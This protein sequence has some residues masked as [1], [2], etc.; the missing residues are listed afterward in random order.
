MASHFD[1]YIPLDRTFHELAI[2]PSEGDDVDLPLQF[3]KRETL[4]WPSLLDEYR[5]ILLSE[6][7]SGKTEEIRNTARALRKDGEH[8]F[9]VR[10]EHVSQDFEDAFEEG[11]LE[12]FNAWAA[13]G[14]EGWLL[15]DSVDE[16]RL[17]DPKDFERAIR[18]L[19]R[20]LSPVLQHAHIVIT[21]R[22]TAWRARTD[23][24][25]CRA[26]FPYYQVKNA[27]DEDALGEDATGF[28]TQQ[29][30]ARTTPTTP[31]KI[32]A[33]DDLH[34]DQIDT[35]LRGRQVKDPKAFRAAVE[36]KDAWSLT[37]RPQ[38]LAE[39][40]EFWNDHQ[41]IGSRF[42]L[43]QS[44]ISRRLEERDQ[45]RSESRPIASKRLRAGAQLVAAASTLA[46]E[47][48][49]RVP[50]GTENSKG[51]AIR[52]VLTDW[53]DVDCATLL[54]RPIFDEGIYG[55]VRFH[56]RSVREYLTAEWLHSLIVDESSRA[57]IEGLFFQSQYGIE[58]VVP[59]MRPVLPWLAILD[60]RILA[61]VCRLA[62][63]ILFEGGDPS[64]LPHETR[65]NILRQAC[66][67]LAQPAHG[68]SLTDYSAVQ[69]F[70]NADLSDDI[71]AL[72]AQYGED[73]D[74]A[75]FL[76]RMV[77]QGEIAGVAAEAKNFA[78][79]SRS[80]YTRIAAFRALATVGSSADQT[81]VRTAFLG[82]SEELNRNW[83]A[84]LIAD[85]PQD[86]QSADWL[87]KAIERSSAKQRFTVDNLMRNLLRLVTDWPLSQLS[88]LVAGFSTLLKTPPVIE[89]RY[90][91]ISTRYGWLTQAAAQSVL[92]LIEARDQSVLEYSALSILRT[93]SLAQENGDSEFLDISEELTKKV[94]EWPE[95]NHALFWHDVAEIRAVRTGERIT[96]YW[97]VSIF[98]HF[99]T[100]DH[101][102]FDT[103]CNDIATRP[104]LD[105]KL[106]ALTLAFS[107]YR[108]NSRPAA[109]RHRLKQLAKGEVELESTLH[110]L[111]H[112][113]ATDRQKWRRQEASWKRRAAQ[114]KKAREENERK[115][116]EYLDANV[117]ALYDS[118][119][120][121]VITD[122]HY[123]LYQRMFRSS[124]SQWSEADWHALIPEFGETIARAFRDGA[125]NFW[126]NHRPRLRSEGAEANSTPFSVIFGLMG[127]SIESLDEPDWIKRLSP[128]EAEVATRFA[129]LELNGFPNW[130]QTLYISQPGVVLD[131]VITEIDF[132][133]AAENPE[134]PSHY[135]LSK[136]SWNGDWMWDRLA[137]LILSRL[138]KPPKNIDNLRYMLSIVQGSSLDGTAIA[139][140][141]MQKTKATRN[142]TTAPRWFAM[143]VG[144]NP[145]VAIPALA[146]RLAELKDDQQK[147][148]FAMSFITALIGG[149]RESRSSRQ[150][151]RTV[152]HM[153]SLYLL[154]HEYVR[155]AEDI[156]RAGTG[157]YSPELRDDAQDA[158]NALFSFI[159]ETPGKE[160]YLALMDISHIH[161]AEKSRPW[162]AF[163]AKRKATLDADGPA[164]APLQ[165]RDF[166]DQLE[167]TPSNHR[168]LWYLAIDR[169]LDLKN[170][171]EE[172]DSS[173][174]SILQAVDRETEIRK[175]IG[176][177]CRERSAGRY[178]IPQEE[179]LADAKRP[180]L[181]FHGVGFDRPVPAE[182]K[183]GDKWT[184][185]HLFERLEIQLCGDYLRDRRSN[186]GIF[187]LV[188]HGTKSSWDLP[189]GR[190]AE[191]FDALLEALQNHWTVL[192]PQYPQV[193]EIKVIGIDLTKRSVDTKTQS[194]TKKSKK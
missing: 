145:A 166:H 78:L 25:L 176:N 88:G 89:R 17:R 80:E 37:T 104:H 23:L 141:A 171:L 177:W 175:F 65:S 136:I 41:R 156:N 132:E 191:S 45:D 24:L 42:E 9:F 10:I 167:R 111:L 76:L 185:P 112:P 183:L 159:S 127:L 1:G 46:K 192:A 55:T 130:L 188:Y 74:I 27:A 129:L 148:H 48:A 125:T 30:A 153:K 150:A 146:A 58:V 5:V 123:Y 180:D 189:N 179:E 143:W 155:E 173:I 47:S 154:M 54:S 162:M 16:A 137:P 138:R 108:N 163:H 174:A 102:C 142:L 194:K 151:Y 190:R 59:T 83:F 18:K 64:Q 181:R 77:W 169:L 144:V 60:A 122:A 71:K 73:D 187:V 98:E 85:L 12:E 51:I 61:R 118:T 158:R 4:R 101:Y 139:K 193:E 152:E 113:P 32:V 66:E 90:C 133:L 70:A 49:I 68:R 82:E 29:V 56:H 62:P 69:R 160:A 81:E 170:D 96:D 52:E 79:N 128:S 57:R 36:R 124:S 50:D 63:E 97:H 91:E 114:Q 126:R 105:D 20:L 117:E 119:K 40:V 15:L 103:C 165:V 172:G 6:A 168:D 34:G 84:E 11:S 120:Q 8:A 86:G 53:D 39:L 140:L 72:L 14:E 147:V 22:T 43:M 21:G 106:V 161:P 7:G 13:S 186:R 3:G 164:W 28:A 115:W 110:S 2:E 131:V 33:L 94:A 100:L 149:R 75:W 26:A 107:I 135:L 44:S 67:Q 109:W 182:L 134:I 157:V 93:L 178:V 87:L 92:R 116:K 38:D 121:C 184:G 95:L 19:G 35:F 99:W 31:F